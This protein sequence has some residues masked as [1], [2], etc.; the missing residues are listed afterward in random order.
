MND[1]SLYKTAIYARKQSK[2]LLREVVYN[3]I[4]ILEEQKA[5]FE[6]N[7]KGSFISGL[8]HTITD[9][10]R[11]LDEEEIF[12]ELNSQIEDCIDPEELKE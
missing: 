1:Y 12:T 10:F 4:K 6:R 3:W 9:D 5:L 11:P 2:D 7:I 8:R